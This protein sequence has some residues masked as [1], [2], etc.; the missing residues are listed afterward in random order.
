[1]RHEASYGTNPFRLPLLHTALRGTFLSA[2]R[3][4][5]ALLSTASPIMAQSA[6]D[7]AF[8]S[9]ASPTPMS[10][11][12]SRQSLVPTKPLEPFS[13]LALGVG[14][15]PLGINLAATTNINQHLNLRGTGNV[16]NYSVNNINT[17]GIQA[18]ANLNFSSAG[19][20]VDYYPFPR[21]GLRLSPGLLF[22]NH[23]GLSGTIT[24]QGGG[25]F[26][27]NHDTYYSSTSNPVA[28]TANVGFNSRNPAFTITTGWGN[29]IP[30]RGG[31]LS[32]PFEIG[33]ALVGAP[34]VNAALASGQVCNE[35]GTG[36]TNAATDQALQTDLQSQV[37]TWKKDLNVVQF[38]PIIS[39]GVAYSFKIR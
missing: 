15:S 33:I 38:Y 26:T 24:E 25:S 1:M 34:T 9:F 18:N 4:M 13:R 35:G 16:F 11:A 37:A 21:H 5:I 36:C 7:H 2:S 39:V 6:V 12:S 27:L 31:H 28:G 22:Y 8:L 17:N 10:G 3:L 30:R 20:S 14:V 19:V 32:F 23:N 29:V